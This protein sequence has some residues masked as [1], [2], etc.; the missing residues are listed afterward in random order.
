VAPVESAPGA[1]LAPAPAAGGGEALAAVS[2]LLEALGAG[3][4]EAFFPALVAGMAFVL[5]AARALAAETVGGGRGRALALH[6]AGPGTAEWG[7][8]EVPWSGGARP[9]HLERE[10]G[11][12]F[13]ALAGILGPGTESLLAVPILGRGTEPIGHLVV[14][15]AHPVGAGDRERGILRILAAHAAAELERRRLE[16]TLGESEERLRDL[17]DEAP[18]A[19]VHEGLDS[20]FLRANRTAM[21]ILGITPDEVPGTVGFSFVPDTPDAQRRLKEA[22]DSIGRGVDTG[23]VVLELRRRNDGQPIFIEWWSRPDRSGTYTRTMFLDVTERVRMEREQERLRAQNLYLREE[24]QSVHNFEEIVG[25]S[26]GLLQV[27]DDVAR[28][29]PTGATVLV[30]GETG[31]GKELIAR[32]IHSRSPRRDKPLIKLNCAAL[33]TSLVESELFGHEKGAFSG[34]IAQRLGRFELAQGGTLFLDEI[35][36]VSLDV[37]VKLL[38]VLQ[39]REFERVGGG[40]PIPVDVRIIAATNRD[41]SQ[42]MAEG[43]FREDLFYRLNVFPIHLPPLRERASDVPLLAAYFLGKVGARIGKRMTGISAAAM[44]RMQAYPWPGNVR[45]LENFVERAV[46]LATGEVLDA[47]PDAAALRPSPA[48]PARTAPGSAPD[49]VDRRAREPGRPGAAAAPPDERLASVERAHILA[50]LERAGWVIEGP[51]GAALALAL[52]PG[53]LRSRMKRLGIARRGKPV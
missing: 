8:E 25:H 33:P 16:R 5:G 43:K 15:D 48:P 7:G 19:Y 26:P 35:G 36:D 46:I 40:T 44:V 39:E 50:A 22:F 49:E 14:S 2:G 18:I 52:H 11:R 13:P 41:L 6:G 37:Q 28:V 53:T 31:T 23:G 10:A 17:F 51:A 45:E 29:A 1:A 32:A 3:T 4:P 24:I 38:R 12:R 34:A 9:C 20:R 47:S 21:R 27:L 42:A 30:T